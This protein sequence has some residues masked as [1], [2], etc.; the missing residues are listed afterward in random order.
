MVYWLI[1]WLYFFGWRVDRVFGGR[2]IYFM[3]GG[4]KD[5]GVVVV[6]VVM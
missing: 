5:V 2:G 1:V 6:Y 4:R 3:F